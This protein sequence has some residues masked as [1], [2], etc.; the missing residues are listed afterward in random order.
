MNEKKNSEDD[1]AYK[2]VNKMNL[3]N[4]IVNRLSIDYVCTSDRWKMCWR[5][6]C[7]DIKDPDSVDIFSM[8]RL[9]CQFTLMYPK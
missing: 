4:L 8:T 1:L 6:C 5:N 9:M 2:T 7:V 3:E